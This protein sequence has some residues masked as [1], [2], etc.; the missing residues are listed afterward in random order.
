MR[1]SK[2]LSQESKSL[3]GPP[4]TIGADPTGLSQGQ[5]SSLPLT[6]VSCPLA[7]VSR[8]TAHLLKEAS[9]ALLLSPHL[10]LKHPPTM[11]NLMMEFLK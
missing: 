2:T 8:A 5:Q 9:P 11:P 4:W 7:R 10:V 6:E 1:L 3:E